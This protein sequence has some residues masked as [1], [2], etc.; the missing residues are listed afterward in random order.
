[1]EVYGVTIPHVLTYLIATAAPRS[2]SRVT[3][4]GMTI[5]VRQLVRHYRQR[6]AHSVCVP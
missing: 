3:V 6:P 1:M 4:I 5:I 2:Y